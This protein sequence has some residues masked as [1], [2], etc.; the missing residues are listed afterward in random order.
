MIQVP[1]SAPSAPSDSS[2][3]STPSAPS[4][5]EAA[6][7]AD[8]SLVGDASRW[9]VG[10]LTAAGLAPDACTDG[11]VVSV[12][13]GRYL[14]GF[15]ATLREWRTKGP[16]SVRSYRSVAHKSWTDLAGADGACHTLAVTIDSNGL[17]RG[18]NFQP[19]IVVP[20]VRDWDQLED[21][22]RIPGVAHSVLAA[23]LEPG[24]TVVLHETDADR[25]MP[26]GSSYKLYVMRAL[27]RAVENGEL[28]WDDEVTV[29]PDL[30]SLPTGDMQELPD[31]TR[32]TV[33]E[34]AYKMIAFSDNTGADLIAERLGRAAVERAVADS[35]HHDPALLRPFLYSRELFEIGWGAPDLRAAW[36]ERD[37]AGR[38]ELLPGLARPLSVSIGDLGETVHQLG[39]DWHMSAYDVLEVLRGLADDGERDT[40]GTVEDILTAYPGLVI[41]REKWPRVFFKAGSCPGVMMFCWLLENRAG[42]RHV[43][44][45]QQAADDQKLIGDGQFLRWLG[46]RVVESGLLEATR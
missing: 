34:T 15:S 19:E 35:G 14:G 28:S 31:G 21:V 32:V 29:R 6:L 5:A 23:R 33:R 44:V 26:A 41:D 17:V 11:R 38:R 10:L 13:P 30:R 20:E 3:P 1:E 25:P 12:F 4:V 2:A 27:V 7:A 18:L 45:L 42:V 9:A 40:T 39:L 8:D 46:G 43:L 16:F 22:V 37:E 24:R 36:T